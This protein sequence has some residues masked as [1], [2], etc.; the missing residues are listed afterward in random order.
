MMKETDPFGASPAMSEKFTFHAFCAT[1][2]HWV[3]GST[4]CKI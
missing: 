4:N 3:T 1:Q 2:V